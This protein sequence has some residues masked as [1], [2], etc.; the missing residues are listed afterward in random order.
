MITRFDFDE[1]IKKLNGCIDEKILAGA[2]E[3]LTEP[4]KS[5]YYYVRHRASEDFSIAR[6]SMSVYGYGKWNFVGEAYD[7]PSGEIAEI[8]NEIPPCCRNLTIPEKIEI[9]KGF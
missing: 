4:E 9:R 7:Y 5:G 8:G 1:I 3:K 6:F 2:L